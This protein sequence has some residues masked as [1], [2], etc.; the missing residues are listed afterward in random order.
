MLPL[1]LLILGAAPAAATD[2]PSRPARE[3]RAPR[4]GLIHPLLDIE[5]FEFKEVRPFKHKVEQLRRELTAKKKVTVLAMYF[6]DL[7]NGLAFGLD[8]QMPF[9]PASLLKLPVMMA[10]MK[11][12]ESDPGLLAARLPLRT[13]TPGEL[14]PYFPPSVALVAGQEYSIDE[15][16][17]AMISRSDNEALHTL[18][19]ALDV[20]DYVRVYEDLG[21]RIPNVRDEDDPVT[22]RE[23]ATF[24]RMLY[25][26]SY[27]SK[28]MSQKSLEYLAASDFDMG[29]EAGVPPTTTVAHK[30]GETGRGKGAPRQLHD[31][32][33]IYHP[34]KPYLLC[35][36]TRGSDMKAMT[37][38]IA[39]TSSLV[40][41]EVNG[42]AK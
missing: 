8:Q 14:E 38:A 27:L 26:A 16:L 13:R 39:A 18:L 23:Y 1:S 34:T 5:E 21:L 41:A 31:C 24:F 10:L 11:K 29:L 28:D 12:Y 2:A 4:R 17:T 25:N 15:L 36:M 22:V 20:K 33:I 35:V 19:A 40:Y 30:F 32:G 6:R 37:E 7:D 3:I 9:Q 42:S